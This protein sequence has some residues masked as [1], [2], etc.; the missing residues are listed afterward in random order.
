M[1]NS[2]VVALSKQSS[3]LM[4][5][6]MS[7]LSFHTMKTDILAVMLLLKLLENRR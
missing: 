4:T 2:S 5:F 6:A 1:S 3:A 7:L